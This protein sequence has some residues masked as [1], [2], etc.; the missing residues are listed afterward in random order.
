[1]HVGIRGSKYGPEDLR[2][3]A[4]F[5]FTVLGTREIEQIGIDGYVDRIRERVGDRPLYLS[6]GYRRARPGVRPGD[7][8]AGGRR[9]LYPRAAG[10][11]PRATRA[12]LI[13]GDIVEVVTALRPR[14]VTSIAAANVAYEIVSL[15]AP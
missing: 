4:G 11:P 5:G 2:E 15:M 3:D 13:G 10:D 12:Q 14:G 1:M 6:L 7:R 9:L 8:H